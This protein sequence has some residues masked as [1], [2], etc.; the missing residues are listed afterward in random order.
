[1]LDIDL[2]TILAEI[3]NFLVI[4]VVL[5]FVLFKPIV[6]RMEENAAKRA[7]LITE[8]QEK[9]DEAQE[10]LNL[11]EERLENIDK[12]IEEHLEKAQAQAQLESQALLEA[13]QKEAEEILLDAEKEAVKLQ[14]QEIEKFHE[15]LVDAVLDISKQVL[16]KTTP[17]E[18]H[19]R[20]VDE[21]NKEIWDLG[22]SDMRQ[23]RT[24]RD[25]LAERLPT[26]YVVSA[27]ELS[28]D[29]Q[30]ALIRTFSALAD[31]NINMEIDIDKDLIA[32]IRVRMGDLIVENSLAMEL[33]EVKSDVAS[34]IEESMSDEE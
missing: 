2:V 23:V 33:T 29:Q 6:K 27:K 26:A 21:L 16:S 24:V 8:A 1:M 10:K 11:I 13:T 28:P 3:L 22:K 18:V 17:P 25:S 31:R 14:Q 4:A 32:G 7:A 34:A 20:L 5:Y 19:D 12:E 30:R 15:D 9:L